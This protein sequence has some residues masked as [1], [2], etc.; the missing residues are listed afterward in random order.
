M[1]AIYEGLI[2]WSCLLLTMVSW[3]CWHNHMRITRICC[4]WSCFEA[5]RTY[6]E[7]FFLVCLLTCVWCYCYSCLSHNQKK[8]KFLY[9]LSLAHLLESIYE[10]YFKIY[11]QIEHETEQDRQTSL[12]RII[13]RILLILIFII[14]TLKLKLLI[15]GCLK[16][17]EQ[18]F[19]CLRCKY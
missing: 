18:D 7:Y 3:R 11:Y 6:D 5:S 19:L 17:I 10:S 15:V 14:L 12:H 8:G 13:D 2:Y 4:L 1:Y 16:H 9:S